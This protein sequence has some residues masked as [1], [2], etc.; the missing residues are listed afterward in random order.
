MRLKEAIAKSLRKNVRTVI[1]A[2]SDRVALASEPLIG[3]YTIGFEPHQNYP[4]YEKLYY[5]D[6]DVAL[7]IDTISALAVGGGMTFQSNS[8]ATVAK[9]EQW[10]KNTNFQKITENNCKTHLVFGNAYSIPVEPAS[11]ENIVELQVLHPAHIKI[12]TDLTGRIEAYLYDPEKWDTKSQYYK[13]YEPD[14]IMHF[15]HNI[16]ANNV[17]GI[18]LLHPC[19]DIMQLLRRIEV[20]ASH[21]AHRD[22]HRLLHVRVEPRDQRELIEDPATGLTPLEIKIKSVVEALSDRVQQLDDEAREFKISNTIGTDDM[23][24]IKDLAASHDWNGLV[25]FVQHL[26]SKA[27]RALRVPPVF[28]GVP[29]GSNRATSTNQLRVFKKYI[30]GIQETIVSEYERVLFPLLPGDFDIEFEIPIAEDDS[31]WAEVA[32]LLYE[33]GI[34]TLDEARQYFG[35]PPLNE[36]EPVM[37]KDI[38]P[39]TLKALHF[40]ETLLR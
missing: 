5:T 18:S 35:L 6:P 11:R 19:Y 36:W 25:N 28:L 22:A 10:A 16:I 33:K 31:I 9:I 39:G 38:L 23:V 7:A 2:V 4:A 24:E 37:P 34:M 3:D 1:K 17:Y 12:K 8:Q 13:E 26:Q 15:R 21:L 30:E 20:T 14:S 32:A 27:Q 40:D 29:E